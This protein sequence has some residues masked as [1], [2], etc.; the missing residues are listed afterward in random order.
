M[1]EHTRPVV[2]DVSVIVPAYRAADTIQRALRSVAD[3]TLRPKEVVV[4]DDGSG[5]G[6]FEAAKACRTFLAPTELK[7]FRQDNA[8]AG[9]ARNRA[10]DNA[11]GEYLAFLDADDDWLA[12]HLEIC[13]RHLL[14][15]GSTLIAHNEWLVEDGIERI[16]DSARRIC[17]WPDPV[18]SVYC[19]G[20]ISTSTIVTRRRAVID[21]G[22]FDPALIN[23]QDVDLWLAVLTRPGASFAVLE[24]PLS[25]YYL[26]AGSINTHTARR[27]KFFIEIA[28]RWSHEI[29]RRPGGGLRA[30]WFR[31]IA[32]HY[33]ALRSFVR[34][35][36]WRQAF[37]VCLR[38]P[39]NILDVSV[40]QVTAAPYKRLN[41]LK[42]VQSENSAA[43]TNSTIDDKIAVLSS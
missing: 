20:C 8:G 24:S 38:A 39:L 31:M 14:E 7:I 19:K 35:G 13:L 2:A 21:A 11:S 29:A 42:H 1:S 4:V 17:E 3:Q 34:A 22:G 26:R 16:N 32:I 18:V 12:E 9:A 10:V 43:A 15:D 40:R 27:F 5:D 28:R 41:F 23:G 36:Q 37:A 6:T 33:E 25:R 30:L